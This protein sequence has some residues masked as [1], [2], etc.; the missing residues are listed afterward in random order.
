VCSN[1]SSNTTAGE[2]NLQPVGFPLV[3]AGTHHTFAKRISPPP[4]G[5]YH[6]S[7]LLTTHGLCRQKYTRTDPN[8]LVHR[9]SASFQL[10]R[11][12]LRR[13]HGRARGG[14]CLSRRSTRRAR[15]GTPA[16][17]RRSPAST[18]GARTG[19]PRSR[20]RCSR[21]QRRRRCG[22]RGSGTAGGPRGPRR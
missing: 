4:F 22:G 20:P 11:A 12:R 9:S 14:L 19:P 18:A 21:T 15:R 13:R 6:N 2:F 5:V 10:R 16:A 7:T 1:R 8:A 17:G 3:D